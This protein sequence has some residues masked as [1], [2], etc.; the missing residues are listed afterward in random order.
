MSSKKVLMVGNEPA[1]VGIL[2][3]RLTSAGYANCSVSDGA[4]ALG[5]VK[6]EKLDLIVMDVL[7][8]RPT[9]LEAMEKIREA[10]ESRRIPAL[11]MSAKGSMRIISRSSQE[12]N[13]SLSPTTRRSS[14]PGLSL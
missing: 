8:P 9:G 4:E 14:F 6:S 10:P 3:T 7:M 2:K 13:S 1:S 5:K 11:I 12:S